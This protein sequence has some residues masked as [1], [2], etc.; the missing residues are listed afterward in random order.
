MA[1]FKWLV[2]ASRIRIGICCCLIVEVCIL[3]LITIINPNERASTKGVLSPDVC[4]GYSMLRRPM[5][6]SRCL[7][8]AV[9]VK[10][11]THATPLGVVQHRKEIMRDKVRVVIRESCRCDGG[12]NNAHECFPSIRE[13]T[14]A[15]H[16]G[17]M[18]Q[19][20]SSHIF[21]C[22]LHCI[23][24][25]PCFFDSIALPVSTVYRS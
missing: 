16:E 10:S 2:R 22:R 15:N 1:R 11:T 4:E 23:P 21:L 20:L 9:P 18:F 17:V 5:G 3:V 8:S 12:S 7:I 6:G 25:Q 14:A 24:F 13:G 19:C